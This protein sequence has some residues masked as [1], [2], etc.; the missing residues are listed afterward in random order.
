M[1]STAIVLASSV[2]GFASGIA[3]VGYVLTNKPLMTRIVKFAFDKNNFEPSDEQVRVLKAIR[4]GIII[5]RTKL[6]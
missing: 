3:T 4:D 6:G 2:A 1:K 5:S